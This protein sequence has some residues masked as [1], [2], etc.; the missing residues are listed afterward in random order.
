MMIPRESKHVAKVNKYIISTECCVGLNIITYY[1][2]V[3]NTSGWRTLNLYNE[4]LCI[5]ELGP[6]FI[7]II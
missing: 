6:E 3:S 5:R 7:N 1:R 2:Y 4:P